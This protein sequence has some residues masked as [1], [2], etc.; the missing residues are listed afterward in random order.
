MANPREFVFGATTLADPDP[1]MSPEQ[2]RNLYAGTHA[3]LTNAAITGPTER[4]GKDIY[5]FKKAVGT[6]G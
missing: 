5:E 3:E 2:V 4:S 1:G 6:K